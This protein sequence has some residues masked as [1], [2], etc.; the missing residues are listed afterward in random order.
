MGLMRINLGGEGE[1]PGVLNQQGRWV[2]R[3]G[4]ASS[5]GGM[6]F[7]ALV[8]AGHRFLIVDNVDLPLPDASY[9]EVITNSTPPEDS[10]TS[11]G[12]TV[13]SSEVRRILKSGGRWVHNGRVK[14]V[15]P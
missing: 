11:L 8:Q 7:E 3:P 2:V 13:Q 4:W 10:F 5:N 1:E 12:P 6:T 9:D 15:K 14:W